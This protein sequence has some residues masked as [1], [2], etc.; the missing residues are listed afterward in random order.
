MAQ[1][2]ALTQND[3]KT[4]IVIQPSPPHQHTISSSK[5]YLSYSLL[6]AGLVLVLV[7]VLVRVLVLALVL[8]LVLV[9]V[10]VLVL[11]TAHVLVLV[12]VIAI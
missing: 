2:L 6:L 3:D 5:Q 8:V 12:L 10:L 4:N 7:R 11:V 1:G 9:R